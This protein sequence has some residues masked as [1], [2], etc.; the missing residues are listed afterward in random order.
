MVIS[1]SKG[2]P[3]PLLFSGLQAEIFVWHCITL[4]Q[5]SAA[6]QPTLPPSFSPSR[7]ITGIHTPLPHS[8]VG[9]H[10]LPCWTQLSKSAFR[11]RTEKSFQNR[12]EECEKLSGDGRERIF[13]L[14]PKGKF[15][16][17]ICLSFDFFFLLTFTMGN[18]EGES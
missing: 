13:P 11:G 16:P 15:K 1:Q 12:L 9:I 14:S 8:S 10:C 4:W 6:K 3:N 7:R 2:H 18:K 17:T 5:T